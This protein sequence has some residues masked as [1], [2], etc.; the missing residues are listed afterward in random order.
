MSME[1]RDH[2][3][4][5]YGLF[6]ARYGNVYTSRQL[7]Q[8]CQQAAGELTP[9]DAV[10]KD[11]DAFFDPYRPTIEPDGFGS[12]EELRESRADHLEAVAELLEEADV[13]VFTFGLTETW[14]NAADGVVYPTCPGTI[15]SE[16]DPARHRFLNLSYAD[17]LADF[18]RF[19]AHARSLNPD[20]HF[21]V[22]VSPVPL[23]ATASGQHV[24]PATLASKSIL[25]A[26]CDELCRRY[27]YVD[28]FP[29][30]ELVASHPMRA[31]FFE[32]N[33]RNVAAAGVE[34]VMSVFFR[35]HGLDNLV[36]SVDDE[37][38]VCDELILETF[39]R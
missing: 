19:A 22:T 2:A 20:L 35:A 23:A 12:E 34:H 15:H 9:T 4:H 25:R 28:Y 11:G 6:S 37:D 7:F 17:V 21:V 14:E 30:Y 8:L 16:F 1:P 39:S 24:L 38:E 27:D 32:P 10:W 36:D 3:K 31:M 26:V 29:S 18:E 33:L 13:F 5:G